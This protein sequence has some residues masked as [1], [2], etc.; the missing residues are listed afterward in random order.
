MLNWIR[1]Y[2][3]REDIN[4]DGLCPTYMVRWT[5][6]RTP[7][8]KVYLHHFLGD[9]WAI[10]PHDHPK[11][12]RSIGLWGSYIEERYDSEGVKIGEKLWRAPWYRFFPAEHIH[13]IR[14]RE[15]GG[16][17]TICI[18]GRIQRDWGFWFQHA[19]IE[20]STYVRQFGRERKDC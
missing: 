9:D 16:A 5:L 10:D 13:R 19:W 7:W 4:G 11:A 1:R 14:S 20:W 3:D 18:V 17:W 12:F 2:L 15:T 8:F 6:L